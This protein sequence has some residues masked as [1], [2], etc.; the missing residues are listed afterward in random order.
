MRSQRSILLHGRF[1][2]HVFAGWDK[3]SNHT[4]RLRKSYAYVAPPYKGKAVPTVLREDLY[5]QMARDLPS[6]C[7]LPSKDQ[8]A[9]LVLKAF[10]KATWESSVTEGPVYAVRGLVKKSGNNSKHRYTKSCNLSDLADVALNRELTASTEAENASNG[11]Y[12]PPD[13]ASVSLVTGTPRRSALD[14]LAHAAGLVEHSPMEASGQF[15]TLEDAVAAARNEGLAL[16]KRRTTV[17]SGVVVPPPMALVDESMSNP[18]W[19]SSGWSASQGNPY[20]MVWPHDTTLNSVV[21]QFHGEE[22]PAVPT[23]PLP[24]PSAGP[25]KRKRASTKGN[26]KRGGQ[27]NGGKFKKMVVCPSNSHLSDMHRQSNGGRS[28]GHRN[29]VRAGRSIELS[30]RVWERETEKA[31]LHQSSQCV[32]DRSKRQ[33]LQ[34]QFYIS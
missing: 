32:F 21:G 22:L 11:Y 29:G 27:T 26:S 23:V 14:D 16:K 15:P 19:Q 33:A 3:G 12:S 7:P 1:P 30:V 8:V 9:A 18:D 24:A 4:S 17:S 10:P 20:A 5:T 6:S 2:R 31:N 25:A 13:S 34:T 28:V